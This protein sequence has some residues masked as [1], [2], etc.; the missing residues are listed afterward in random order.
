M[1]SWVKPFAEAYNAAAAENKKV[2]DAVDNFDK[3]AEAPNVY[4]GVDWQKSFSLSLVIIKKSSSGQEYQEALIL[5]WLLIGQQISKPETSKPANQQTS[6]PET[7]K[8]AKHEYGKVA[9]RGMRGGLV[10]LTLSPK[11]GVR[12]SEMPLGAVSGTST[13]LRFY[14]LRRSD[15]NRKKNTL[16][17]DFGFIVSTRK[18]LFLKK[19]VPHRYF[20]RGRLSEKYNYHLRGLKIRCRPCSGVHTFQL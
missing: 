15:R 2:G 20:Q 16:P 11:D 4:D 17:N 18:S 13:C 12:H 10:C 7:C 9:C 1:I 19:Y 6:K 8:P 14:S 5:M 3:G